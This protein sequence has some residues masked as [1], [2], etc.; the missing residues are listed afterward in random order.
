MLP[1]EDAVPELPSG[2]VAF[3]FADLP[4]AASAWDSSY[5]DTATRVD[6]MVDVL[7]EASSSHS[8]SVFKIIGES[9]QS[10]FPDVSHALSAAIDAQRAFATLWPVTQLP[11]LAIHVGE[12][13]PRGGD[14]LAPALNRLARL[15][16]ASHPGQIVLTEAARELVPLLADDVSLRDLGRHRLRDLLEA[17]RAFQVSAVGLPTSF[18]PLRG[19]DGSPHNLP[20]QPTCLIGREVDLARVHDALSAGDRLITLLGPG[21]VGKTRLALQIGADE[22]DAFPDGVWWVPLASVTDPDL[23]LEAI[24]SALPLRL[25]PNAPLTEALASGLRSRRD[26]LIL[27]NL[28]QVPDAALNIDRLLTDAPSTV[29]LVT[30][31]LPLGLPNETEMLIQPLAMPPE[32]RESV[33]VPSAL[34]S[35]AV[36]LFVERA[37]AIR[38]AFELTPANVQEVVSICRRLD[39]LPLAIEL[40]AARIRVLAPDALLD[41]LDRS[42]SVLTGGARDLPDR[43][44]TLRGAIQWSYDLLSPVQRTA[45]ARLAVMAPAFTSDAAA[46]TFAVYSGT[47]EVVATLEEMAEQSLLRRMPGLD[48][49]VRWNM[50][51]TIHE[52]ASERLRDLPEAS[53]LRR[54]HATAYLSIAGESEWFEVSNQPELAATFEADLDNYRLALQTLRQSGADGSNDMLRLATMLAD[55]WWLRGHTTEG[56][57]WLEGAIANAADHVS[58]DLGRA[59]ASAGLL[60]EAQSDVVAA[61]GFQERALEVFRAEGHASGVADALTGLAVIARAEGNL[62]RAR[63]LHQEAFD[64]W[65]ALGDE[66]GAAGA[67]LDL[68][69]VTYLR[70]DIRNAMPVLTEALTIF[71]AADDLPGI[72]YARQS[73]AVVAAMEGRFKDAI[74]EFRES[75]RVWEETGNEQMAGTERMNLAE[76]LLLDGEFGEAQSL[77]HRVITD[78]ELANDTARRATALGLRA[79]IHLAL[80]ELAEAAPLLDDALRLAWPSR[81]IA[82]CAAILDAMAEVS[83]KSG[84]MQRARLLVS[85]S[86]QL[87]MQSGIKRM[88]V[89][90]MQLA[91]LNS[92]L[93]RDGLDDSLSPDVIIE[94]ETQRGLR[95]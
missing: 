5:L 19:L 7:S 14:Y 49:I 25:P 8:G 57:N 71:T 58:L 17:E 30:S 42:L 48:G 24:A 38:A 27:D 60:A 91:S 11:R 29:A 62:D 41:R 21:G 31:R 44:Q 72:G 80:G 89:Y 70:G 45:F 2:L 13:T 93:C 63:I 86:N 32:S 82:A 39:G 75:L 50:L 66:Q 51:S 87:R 33:S 26:L 85:A 83:A 78:F 35:P 79:R 6:Q 37:Q 9:A 18:P 4:S 15:T 59:L 34:E 56:R 40:A 84:D 3:L 20:V 76:A 47:P 94:R 92:E 77:L 68:G 52:F 61:R 69:V 67:L 81:D 23:V 95:R 55:F 74:V 90:A 54:A 64:V 10:A 46:R 12:A 73:L 36:Q 88:P 65:S 22:L 1:G 16:S 53:E 28:E 43:Q